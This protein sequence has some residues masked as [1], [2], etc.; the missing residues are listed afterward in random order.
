MFKDDRYIGGGKLFFKPNKPAAIEFELA[1]VQDVKY[2]V[3]V[4]TKEI[5]TY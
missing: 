5:T 1:E 2:K 3:N 4:V